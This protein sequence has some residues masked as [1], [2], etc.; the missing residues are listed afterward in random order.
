MKNLG[1]ECRKQMAK[2][3]KKR[4]ESS[5]N[6]FIAS[7]NGMPVPEQ[8][9]LRRKLKEINVSLVVVKNRIAKQVFQQSDL[10][11]FLPM[12]RGLTAIALGGEDCI[13]P[14]KILMDFA[15]KSENFKIL[16]A[17]VDQQILDSNSVKRLAAIPSRE[18]LL[19]QVFS[20]FK[21]PIQGLVNTL[22]ATIKKFVFVLDKIKEKK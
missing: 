21:S 11:T 17:Y 5:T 14:S 12:M 1:I 18:A 15:G 20:G 3:I 22:S 19:A 9:Q 10:Q 4:L 2:E 16:A 6:L 7:F 13:S 8:D